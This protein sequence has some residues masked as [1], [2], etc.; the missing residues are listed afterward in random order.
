MRKALD[1]NSFVPTST[2]IDNAIRHVVHDYTNLVWAA[3]AMQQPTLFPDMAR[4]QFSFAYLQPERA[5]ADFFS[6]KRANASDQRIRD[7]HVDMLAKDF[8]STAVYP[9]QKW[10]KWKDFLN[11]SLFHL[12]YFRTDNKTPFDPYQV[13]MEMYKEFVEAWKKFIDSLPDPHSTRFKEEIAKKHQEFPYLP[14]YPV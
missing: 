10:V 7:G 12:G 3:W 5:F 13:L 9:L 11:P 6:G 8:L 2:M 4:M 14:L 1:V